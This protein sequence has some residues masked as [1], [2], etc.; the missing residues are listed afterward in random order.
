MNQKTSGHLKHDRHGTGHRIIGAILAGGGLFWLT[1]SLGWISGVTDATHIVWPI[2]L[3][4]LGLFMMVSTRHRRN[5]IV[6]R[7][8]AT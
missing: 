1:E 5:R 4:V 6:G 7:R 2:V 8:R 3:I